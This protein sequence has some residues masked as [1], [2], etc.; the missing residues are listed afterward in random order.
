MGQQN[1]A[2]AEKTCANGEAD[3]AALRV[4]LNQVKPVTSR[5][6]SEGFYDRQYDDDRRCNSWHFVEKTQLFAR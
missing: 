5:P 6:S 1:R 4:A 3:G 2:F